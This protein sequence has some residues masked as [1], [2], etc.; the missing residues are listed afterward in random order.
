MFMF[1]IIDNCSKIQNTTAESIDGTQ[2]TLTLDL[3]N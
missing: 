1:A 2:D 3:K